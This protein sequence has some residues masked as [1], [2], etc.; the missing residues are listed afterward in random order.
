MIISLPQHKSA[1]CLVVDFKFNTFKCKIGIEIVKEVGDF[2]A[3]FCYWQ[4][5]RLG[6]KT[7]TFYLRRVFQTIQYD[8]LT[9]YIDIANSCVQRTLPHSWLKGYFGFT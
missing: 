3:T 5:V 2:N 6:I 7:Y 4:A 1:V 8:S 9:V